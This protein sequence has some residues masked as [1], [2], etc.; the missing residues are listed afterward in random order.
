M[1]ILLSTA[2][3]HLETDAC[4]HWKKFLRVEY[5]E[6]V[7]EYKRVEK[8]KPPVSWLLLSCMHMCVCILYVQTIRKQ[9]ELNYISVYFVFMIF[10]WI[11]IFIFFFQVNS[12]TN[13]GW[14]G[15]LWYFFVL[16][17]VHDLWTVCYTLFVFI[18]LLVYLHAR[19]GLAWFL[20][21]TKL[22]ERVSWIWWSRCFSSNHL[23]K[24]LV[25][26]GISKERECYCKLGLYICLHIKAL[27]IYSQSWTVANPVHLWHTLSNE[28]DHGGEKGN[29]MHLLAAGNNSY[30]WMP[31]SF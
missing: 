12:G 15:A 9:R 27:S 31:L 2:W 7:G 3:Q 14:N 6:S 23:R 26:F 19:S 17:T 13:I 11:F 4:F 25:W 24:Y 5:F 29:G 10:V 16:L 1:Y 8:Y 22:S 20:L 21:H 18:Y 30:C 28:W